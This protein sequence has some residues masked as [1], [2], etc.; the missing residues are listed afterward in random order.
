MYLPR[1]N[2]QILLYIALYSTPMRVR[3]TYIHIVQLRGSGDNLGEVGQVVREVLPQG[4]RNVLGEAL[5]GLGA[6]GDGLDG[7]P[8]EGNLRSRKI[9]CSFTNLMDG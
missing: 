6:S 1:E 3:C 4:V 9:Y 8:D 2:S 7:K 5:D